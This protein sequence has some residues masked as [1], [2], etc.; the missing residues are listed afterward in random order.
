MTDLWSDKSPLN[1]TTEEFV[2]SI[3]DNK[4]L[5]TLFCYNWGN[6]ATIPSE[7][8]F[9]MQALLMNHFMRGSF[10][11]GVSLSEAL[12]STFVKTQG[13]NNSPKS[14]AHFCPKTQPTSSIFSTTTKNFTNW[15]HFLGIHKNLNES[16]LLK[17]VP[18]MTQHPGLNHFWMKSSQWN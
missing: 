12:F 17:P 15:K 11:P 4:D 14:I 16:E 10:Y 7:S 13:K 5:Q 3:T 6:Y 9:S 8:A 18:K 2:K 1:K